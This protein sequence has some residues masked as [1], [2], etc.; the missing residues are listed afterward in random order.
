MRIKEPFL[1]LFSVFWILAAIIPKKINRGRSG[2]PYEN[3]A[4]ARAALI[5]I[6]LATLLLWY[7]LPWR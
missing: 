7:S 1:L 6:G 5:V 2:V 4:L 3:Q